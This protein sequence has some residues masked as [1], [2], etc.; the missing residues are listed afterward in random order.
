[1]LE[2]IQDIGTIEY[3]KEYQCKVIHFSEKF[4][5]L[6][7]R[8]HH[9]QVKSSSKY[10]YFTGVYYFEGPVFW[11][12]ADFEIASDEVSESVWKRVYPEASDERINQV[13]KIFQVCS[14]KSKSG[15]IKVAYSGIH[16]SDEPPELTDEI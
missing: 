8:I 10:V 12:G 5:N 15:L 6:G 16:V 9:D 13:A 4:L 1:M 3:L 2:V 7:I 11:S 14:V